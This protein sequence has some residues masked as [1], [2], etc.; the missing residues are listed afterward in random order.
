MVLLKFVFLPTLTMSCDVTQS[1][2][3]ALLPRILEGISKCS[4][5]A[6]DAEFT[7]LIADKANTNRYEYNHQRQS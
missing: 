6:F 3:S 7:A 1:N 5:V 4:F 2:F